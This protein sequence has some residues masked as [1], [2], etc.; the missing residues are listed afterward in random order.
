MF[1]MF[2]SQ[3]NVHR[4]VID[5]KP[6]T[7]KCNQQIF[8]SRPETVVLSSTV[9]VQIARRAETIPYREALLVRAMCA[10]FRWTFSVSAA[11]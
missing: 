10:H 6:R 7:S 9:D 11:I 8:L 5:A 4:W 1:S 3:D 2:I